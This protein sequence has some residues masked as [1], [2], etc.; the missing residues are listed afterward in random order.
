[1]QKFTPSHA[2]CEIV[3]CKISRKFLKQ[4]TVTSN[5]ATP[6]KRNNRKTQSEKKNTIYPLKNVAINLHSSIIHNRKTETTQMSNE[7]INK[8]CI[9]TQLVLFDKKKHSLINAT[10]CMTFEIIMLNAHQQ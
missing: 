3:K 8:M 4:V 10:V 7:Q 6:L 1:M 2:A 9:C 5:S